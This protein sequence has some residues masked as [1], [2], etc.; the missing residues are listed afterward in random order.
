[1]SQCGRDSAKLAAV[2][3]QNISDVEFGDGLWSVDADDSAA[4]DTNLVVDP[5]DGSVVAE[6]QDRVNE[7][8]RAAVAPAQDSMV[9]LNVFTASFPSPHAK[10]ATSSGT[11]RLV[12]GRPAA[13]GRMVPVR[14]PP[15]VPK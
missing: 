6:E 15:G 13:A 14:M 8:R 10:M 2:G 3:Y 12:P 5:D 4:K 11:V 1:M 9:E 7:M